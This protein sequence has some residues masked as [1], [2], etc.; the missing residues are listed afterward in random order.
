ML[1][2]LGLA[3]ILGIVGAIAAPSFALASCVLPP[4]FEVS[5]RRAPAVFVGTVVDLHNRDRSATVEV[6][7]VWKGPGI[8]SQVVVH[9]GAA[10]GNAFTSVDR[11][12]ELSLEYLFVPY[13]RNGSVFRDNACTRT[14]PFREELTRFRPVGTDEPSPTPTTETPPPDVGEGISTVWLAV[15]AALAGAALIALVLLR[16]R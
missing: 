8:S 12:F 16:R 9:G 11:T 10:Q 5:I 15:G 1:I 2:H 6:R 3:T 7:E 13:E 4:L 14:T